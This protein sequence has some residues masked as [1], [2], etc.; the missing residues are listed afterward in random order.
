MC[1]VKAATRGKL[2][3]SGCQGH[4]RGPIGH[5]AGTDRTR[6]RRLALKRRH[7]SAPGRMACTERRACYSNPRCGSPRIA[8]FK[9]ASVTRTDTPPAAVDSRLERSG[10]AP[11]VPRPPG[12][13]RPTTSTVTPTPPRSLRVGHVRAGPCKRLSCIDVHERTNADPSPK[14]GGQGHPVGPR[15]VAPGDRRCARSDGP[16]PVGG[17][18]VN[19]PYR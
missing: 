1:P 8:V 16:A 18:D 4:R 7:A 5:A 6:V 17:E 11:A 3:G 2:S 19:D 9:I 12:R 14:A 13:R 10:A 15:S